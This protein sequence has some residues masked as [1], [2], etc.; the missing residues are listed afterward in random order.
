MKFALFPNSS[1]QPSIAFAKQ[2]MAFLI[3]KGMSVIVDGRFASEI[4]APTVEETPLDSID[5]VLSFGGDGTMLRVFHD[6]PEMT[7]PIL[8]INLGHL[9]FLADI[10]VS[11]AYSALED[12]I[13]GAYTIE[14][15]IMMDGYTPNGEVC[16]ALNDMVVHRAKNPSLIELAIHVDGLYLN[17]FSADGIIIA[18]PTGS[19]AYSLAAGGPILS[20][21]I[22][23][24]TLTPISAH[25]ISNRPIVLMPKK[26]III[27][28]LSDYDPVE[29]T[30]DGV[31]R[32]SIKTGEVFKITKSSKKFK[33]VKLPHR[34]Y[35]SI[36]RSK[37]GWT[38]KLR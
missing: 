34:D 12:I 11:E 32:Y 1:K 27:Q 16:S 29:I 18:T 2:V 21:E 9:G 8:G 28:Y 24:F 38:G 3:E 23:A 33:L 10:P 4:P 20:P 13:Q 19:T 36:L 6:Y 22:D 30:F 25:T 26:E 5:I 17:T 35:F 37:L 15:R 31:A 7:A 14:E